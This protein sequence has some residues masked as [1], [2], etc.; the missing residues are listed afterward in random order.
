MD[1]AEF[2]LKDQIP[3]KTQTLIPAT[4]KTAYAAAKVLADNEPMLKVPSAEDNFGRIISWA[5]D[6]GF[7]KLLESGQWRKDNGQ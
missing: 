3:V 1:Q 2:F 6:F 7:Q 4:L 5:V